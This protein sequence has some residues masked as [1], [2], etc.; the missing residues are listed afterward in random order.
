W[1]TGGPPYSYKHSGLLYSFLGVPRL[2]GAQGKKRRQYGETERSM[3]TR[4]P[5]DVVCGC[6]KINDLHGCWASATR[7]RRTVGNFGVRLF[8]RHA[9]HGA[10]K[11]VTEGG[12]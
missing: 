9:A 7:V 11:R 4:H 8:F 10:G 5:F 6:R 1:R 2:E 3:Q 12:G